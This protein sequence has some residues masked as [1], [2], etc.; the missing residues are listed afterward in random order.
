M[1][2]IKISKVMKERIE[3]KQAELLLESRVKITQAELLERIVDKALDNQEFM[4]DLFPDG[5]TVIE[6]PKK[7]VIATIVH[8]TKATP[9]FFKDEWED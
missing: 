4:D 2:S 8:K 3:Q 7:P 6:P 9:R 1:Q 5:S